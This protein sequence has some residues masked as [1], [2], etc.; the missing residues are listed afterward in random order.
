M[1]SLLIF[2]GITIFSCGAA[3]AQTGFA[4]YVGR[5][6]SDLAQRMGPP[7]TVL[8]GPNGWP[9]FQWNIGSGIKGMV[10][11]GLMIHTGR[12]L[13]EVATRPATSNPTSMMVDWVNDGGLDNGELEI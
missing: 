1:K 5:P 10:V 3:P 13:L 4:A 11:E 9:I 7:T 6:V 8:R 12:C 2:L